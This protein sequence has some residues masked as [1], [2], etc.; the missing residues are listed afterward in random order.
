[1][2]PT[3]GSALFMNVQY[4]NFLKLWNRCWRLCFFGEMNGVEEL[5]IGRGRCVDKIQESRLAFIPDP[6]N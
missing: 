5:W 2:W 3:Q 6:E 1:M 4:R